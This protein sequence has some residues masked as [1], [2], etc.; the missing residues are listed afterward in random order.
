MVNQPMAD[1]PIDDPASVRLH[2]PYYS[3]E[4]KVNLC[5]AACCQMIL[6]GAGRPT[7]FCAVVS[8]GLDGDCC[9]YADYDSCDQALW[10]DALFTYFG[11]SPIWTTEGF[12]FGNARYEIDARR[13]V[14]A[15]L[16]F[17]TTLHAV[18]IVGY[19][20]DGDVL[21]NDPQRGQQR[22]SYDH[23][24]SAYAMGS[25]YGAYHNLATMR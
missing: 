4:N 2:I 11:M 24:Q 1:K 3:Q 23:L 16:D 20:F 25:W 12:S 7:A 13:P 10:P 19:Y 5:W 17:T 18:L 9:R 8:E 14:T 22:I 21:V 6:A 15:I